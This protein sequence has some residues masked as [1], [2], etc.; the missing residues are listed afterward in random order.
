MGERVHLTKNKVE[1]TKGKLSYVFFTVVVTNPG[2]K[3][4]S[5]GFTRGDFEDALD[6]VSRP[7]K[8]PDKA[9]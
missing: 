1:V 9:S 6:K 4:T 3:T 5:Q 2:G 8:K 7:A